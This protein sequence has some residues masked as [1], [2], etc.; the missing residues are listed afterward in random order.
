MPLRATMMIPMSINLPPRIAATHKAALQSCADALAEE[1]DFR[2]LGLL[3]AGSVARSTADMFSDIDL[4]AV[5]DINWHQRRRPEV[6]GV[7]I[8]LFLGRPEM[9]VDMVVKRKDACVHSF[10]TGW[11]VYDPYHVID[12]LQCLAFEVY[13]MP[14]R[15]FDGSG[16][17]LAVQRLNDSLRKFIRLKDKT[18]V[19]AAFD[20]QFLVRTGLDAY[21]C[22][23]GRWRPSRGD[24]LDDLREHAPSIYASIA[25]LL[26]SP[27]GENKERAA[28]RL[29]DDIFSLRPEARHTSESR[30]GRFKLTRKRQDANAWTAGTL[31]ARTRNDTRSQRRKS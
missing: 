26:T 16:M 30:R 11:N 17:F 20:A 22:L 15:G 19:H 6:H 5:L 2:L 24:I 12:E 21:Y 4:Y 25:T 7:T 3:L 14:S 13:Q 18:G 9:L 31:A 23:S 8:D 29:V 10:A 27:R 1:F 28:I